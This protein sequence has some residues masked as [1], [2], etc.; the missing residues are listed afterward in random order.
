MVLIGRLIVKNL[1]NDAVRL[2][3]NTS[4]IFYFFDLIVKKYEINNIP[5]CT[6]LWHEM[7]EIA[8]VSGA[9]IVSRIQLPVDKNF[10]HLLFF[11]FDLL[12]N[13]RLT[14]SQNALHY[15]MKCL[16]L[17]RFLGLRLFHESSFQLTKTS[18][19][20][21]FS[22]LIVKKY[23]INNIPK[24]TPLWHEMFEIA[25]VSGASRGAGEL[26]TLPQPP[27]LVAAFF[28]FTMSHY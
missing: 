2:Q 22:D 10:F 4:F 6:P 11:R 7:F 9:P 23:E 27:Y 24:C 16:K 25:S 28:T 20:Y 15:G 21:Y 17:R 18:F 3:H 5:K 12:K 14:T 19:I 26:T 13:M 8:S 1:L